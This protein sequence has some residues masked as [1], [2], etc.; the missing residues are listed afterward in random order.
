MKNIEV[1]LGGT[2][3]TVSGA[4]RWLADVMDVLVKKLPHNSV[5]DRL[6]ATVA[7]LHSIAAEAKKEE[8]RC[9]PTQ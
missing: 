9:P 8:D 1:T 3:Y 7:Q 5:R 6:G 4:I 2:K